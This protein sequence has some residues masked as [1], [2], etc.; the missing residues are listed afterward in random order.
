[1]VDFLGCNALRV[2]SDWLPSSKNL[3]TDVEKNTTSYRC[4]KGQEVMNLHP[5]SYPVTC[6]TQE[7]IS[8]KGSAFFFRIQLQGEKMEISHQFE[9]LILEKGKQIS[10]LE[11]F[12]HWCA[13]PCSPLPN[14]LVLLR[15]VSVW[16][17]HIFRI[18]PQKSLVDIHSAHPA[19]PARKHHHFH[20][21]YTNLFDKKQRHHFRMKKLNETIL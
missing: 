17:T 4:L 14:L 7:K 10:G 12:Q 16:D 5:L 13:S 3:N 21:S 19:A 15:R 2:F 11:K 9:S 6:V 18:S 20:M 8:R 1:M